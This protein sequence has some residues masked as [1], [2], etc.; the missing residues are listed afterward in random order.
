MPEL[1]RMPEVAAGAETATLCEWIVGEN[2]HYAANDV[3]ATIETD[4]AV[5]DFTAD[6]DGVLLRVLVS[7][8]T[9]AQVGTPIALVQRAGET[10]DDVDAG[11]ASLAVTAS[12]TV[13]PS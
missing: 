8:G 10:V 11:L 4:K 13:P 7:A 9:E 3:L 6:A 5:V 12:S 1:L 2:Q